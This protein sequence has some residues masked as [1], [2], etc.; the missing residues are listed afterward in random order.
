MPTGPG[1]YEKMKTHTNLS[2]NDSE[3]H[4]AKQYQNKMKLG[5]P[6]SEGPN[7]KMSSHKSSNSPNKGK[8]SGY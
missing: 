7:K 3:N 4:R 8:M 1:S 2:A 5:S 6:A